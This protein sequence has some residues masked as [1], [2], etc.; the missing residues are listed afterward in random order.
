[1]HHF[2]P[3]YLCPLYIRSS[4][5]TMH[6]FNLLEEVVVVGALMRKDIYSSK[7][8]IGIASKSWIG[9]LDLKMSFD[10]PPQ[11]FLA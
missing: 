7:K 2:N 1:M 4:T 10:I 5:K 9:D 11:P 3:F 8:G 6:H